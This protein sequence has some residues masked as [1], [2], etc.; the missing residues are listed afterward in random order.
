[1]IDRSLL[2]AVETLLA[3]QARA[4]MRTQ[5]AELSDHLRKDMGISTADVVRET[6]KPFWID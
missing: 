6:S 4:A 5:M 3:W 1:A 2:S